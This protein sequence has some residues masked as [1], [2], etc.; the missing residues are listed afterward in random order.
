VFTADGIAHPNLL[1]YYKR[2]FVEIFT[3]IN[4]N[5]ISLIVGFGASSIDT[6]N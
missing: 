6:I 2:V 3:T 5:H 1:T 4:K